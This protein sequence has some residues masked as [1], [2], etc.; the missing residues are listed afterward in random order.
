MD[1]GVCL[2]GGQNET[3]V[4]KRSSRRE[5][6]RLSQT[7]FGSRLMPLADGTGQSAGVT[8]SQRT[9]KQIQRLELENWQLAG[10]PGSRMLTG[11]GGLALTLHKETGIPCKA[12]DTAD[13]VEGNRH[14]CNQTELKGRQTN[15]HTVPLYMGSNV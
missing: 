12:Q 6:S 1:W 11:K 13:Q 15:A 7:Q 2:D 3:T 14:G 10:V 8:D 9:E 5:C 4:S